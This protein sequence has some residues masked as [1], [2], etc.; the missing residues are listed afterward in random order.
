MPEPTDERLVWFVPEAWPSP[1]TGTEL[2]QGLLAAGEGLEIVSGTDRLV[3]FG[4]GIEHDAIALRW[5]QSVTIRTS[6]RCLRLVVG[7]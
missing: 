1:A 3:V 2:T 7:V 5:G 6:D 4:D